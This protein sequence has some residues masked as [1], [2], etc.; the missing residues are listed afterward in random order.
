MT[1]SRGG[2]QFGR[3]R[4]QSRCNKRQ[5]SKWK[6]RSGPGMWAKGSAVMTLQR[7]RRRHRPAPAPAAAAVPPPL[8]LPRRGGLLAA[9]EKDDDDDD[10]GGDGGHGGPMMPR[11][12]TGSALK[13]EDQR[14]DMTLSI[15][16]SDTRATITRGQTVSSFATPLH[17]AAALRRVEASG[18]VN[19]LP[20]STG[21]PGPA[22]T[23]D[24]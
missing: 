1:T 14:G 12:R 24:I 3:R 19:G 4:R 2:K 18:G 13:V 17:F 23:I 5:S 16:I 10:G 11:S 21:H 9:S 7:R 8:T 22:A 15:S 20:P 6:E